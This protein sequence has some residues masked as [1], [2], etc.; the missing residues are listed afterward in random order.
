MDYLK[1]KGRLFFH[2]ISMP[3]IWSLVIPVVILDIWI[4]L[5]H[6]TCFPL[7]G[8]PYVKRQNYVLIDRHKLQYLSF[9]QKIGCVYCGYVNGIIHYWSEIGGRTEKYWCG[10]MHHKKKGFIPPKHH[11]TFLRY[12]DKKQFEQFTKR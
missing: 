11:V 3:I 5:Y 2:I 1:R 6:R 7:Y 9:T 4:E 10:I 12:G 8:I